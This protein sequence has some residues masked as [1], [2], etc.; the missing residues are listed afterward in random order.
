M[1]AQGLHGQREPPT[2]WPAAAETRGCQEE[3]GPNRS[4]GRTART[5]GAS[6]NT[7]EHIAE[8]I[9]GMES[10]ARDPKHVRSTTIYI[11]RIITLGGIERIVG[12]IPSAV[13]Q[14]IPALKADGLS[15]P[16]AVNAPITAAKSLFS[17][18]KRNGR[19]ADYALETLAKLNE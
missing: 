14:A 19:C 11:E 2:N 4:Q 7:G 12:L 13:E 10:K 1:L 18:A 3:G 16:C 6:P 9:A 8:F 15:A 5:G 17:M